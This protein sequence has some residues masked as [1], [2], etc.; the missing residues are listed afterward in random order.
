MGSLQHPGSTTAIMILRTGYLSFTY[1]EMLLSSFPREIEKKSKSRK[2]KRL[3]YV[4]I[5]QEGEWNA[6]QISNTFCKATL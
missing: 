2:T 1:E 4:I 6:G 5:P 3:W